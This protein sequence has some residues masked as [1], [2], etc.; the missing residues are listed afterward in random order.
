MFRAFST[1]VVL[2]ISAFWNHFTLKWKD[3][4]KVRLLKSQ[5]EVKTALDLGEVEQFNGTPDSHPTGFV[6][7][8]P[9]PVLAPNTFSV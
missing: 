2:I 4:S 8:C 6:V 5:N 3:T 9:V 1:S 7:N